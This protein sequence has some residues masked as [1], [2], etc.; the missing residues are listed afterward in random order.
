MDKGGAMTKPDRGTFQGSLAC[1]FEIY[2]L[3]HLFKALN[4]LNAI[5]LKH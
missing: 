4:A 1:I 5:Y 2:A 3:K